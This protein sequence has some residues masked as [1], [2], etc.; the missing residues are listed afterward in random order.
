MNALHT[1]SG[2]SKYE[3]SEITYTFYI[4]ILFSYFKFIIKN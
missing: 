2:G 4:K 3:D 1:E